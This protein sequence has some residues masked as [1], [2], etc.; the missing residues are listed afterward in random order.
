MT[1]KNKQNP[2]STFQS[3]TA[4]QPNQGLQLTP[5]MLQQLA[6]N[7]QYQNNDDE[8]DLGELFKVIWAGKFKIIAITAVF[9]IASVFY[10]LSLPNTYK[11]EALLAPATEE[12]GGMGGLAAKFG[13]LASLAGV[14]LGS[15]GTDKTGLAIEIMK[16]RQF[17][18]KFINDNELLVPLMAAENWDQSS[19][20][21]ILDPELYDTQSKKWIRE[22]KAPFKPT[23]SNQ[24]AYK[25]FKKIVSIS[26]DKETSMVTVSIEHYSPEIAKQWV[27]KL[28]LAINAEMKIRDLTE[29][30]KSIDYIEQQLPKTKLAD[31]QTVLYQI[32]E[33]QTKTIM[34]AQVRD[35]YAFNTIDPAL[36]PERKSGPKRILICV[37]A[38]LLGG[39]LSIALVLVHHVFQKEQ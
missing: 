3:E 24:E 35:E 30:Q 23:P 34:F 13:G 8:I 21:L 6:F 18:T 25:A 37:L 19:N 7:Q 9:A 4:N 14:N 22:A 33:E 39:I 16:S 27:D 15:G 32:M 2:D 10:A 17:I 28:I 20:Q 12:S 11:S 29:A 26:Q 1:D 31:L 5:E 38:L 36:I